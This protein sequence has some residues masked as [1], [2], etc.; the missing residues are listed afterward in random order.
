MLRSILGGSADLSGSVF[1]VTVHEPICTE[2]G[3]LE[4]ALYGSFLP[5]PLQSAFPL[6]DPSSYARASG[7][8]AVVLR[9]ENIVINEKRECVRLCVTN[10][11]DRPIQ[12]GPLPHV[13][14]LCAQ[15]R[16]QI[17]SHYHFIEAN[18]ALQFDRGRAYGMRLNIVSGTAVRFEP[19]DKKTVTLCAIAGTKDICG[20]NGCASGRYDLARTDDIV[21]ALV[22]RGFGHT[23]E[24]DVHAFCKVSDIPRTTYAAMFGPTVGDRIRLGDTALW[25]EVEKDVV[26]SG[27]LGYRHSP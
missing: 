13:H 7:P 9:K 10:N 16:L 27:V 22:Q 25:V 3:N 18:K 19:G 11:G 23:P 6:R 12:V 8:G 4:E 2:N 26:R 17:G 15:N 14:C 21:Q 5:V 24:P 20:G 1:L